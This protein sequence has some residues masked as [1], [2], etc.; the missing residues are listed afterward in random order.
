MKMLLGVYD[1]FCIVKLSYIGIMLVINMFFLQSYHTGIYGT[2]I[3][4]NLS[5]RMILMKKL[6][7]KDQIAGRME[8]Q[9]II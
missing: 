2:K 5:D 4:K 8:M 7:V 1:S 6:L 9:R 3:N